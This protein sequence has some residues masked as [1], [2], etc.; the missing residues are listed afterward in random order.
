MYFLFAEDS[1]VPQL[2]SHA[3]T[4]YIAPERAETGGMRGTMHS[5]TQMND[6]IPVTERAVR[7]GQLLRGSTR[8]RAG[9]LATSRS[10]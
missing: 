8:G 6:R 1:S 3:M 2:A 4:I 7:L 9:M 5:A 10:S